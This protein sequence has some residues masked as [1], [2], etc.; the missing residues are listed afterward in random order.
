[1][2]ARVFRHAA[3][4]DDIIAF[5]KQINRH[6]HSAAIRFLAE[7]EESISGLRFMPGRGS[8][9]L[10]PDG[11]IDD[12]RTWRIAGFPDFLILYIYRPPDVYVLALVHGRQE[13]WR[14][15]KQRLGV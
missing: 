12:V 9:K 5:G 11:K 8:L 2:T 1:V 4:D 6:N 15:V 10:S 14:V 3:L 7:A 13:Y